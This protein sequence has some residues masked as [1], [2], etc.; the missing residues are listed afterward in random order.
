MRITKLLLFLHQWILIYVLAGAHGGRQ[1]H[2]AIPGRHRGVRRVPG[3]ADIPESADQPPIRV[4]DAGDTDVVWRDVGIPGPRHSFARGFS[5]DV[6]VIAFSD[7][8]PE[9]FFLRSCLQAICKQCPARDHST[10]G[11]AK[12][13]CIADD[14]AFK[15]GTYKD[16]QGWMPPAAL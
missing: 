15:A 5:D 7:R 9:T 16:G 8:Y 13:R 1:G 6:L 2:A 12:A 14:E 10:Q 4:P 11:P 3:P